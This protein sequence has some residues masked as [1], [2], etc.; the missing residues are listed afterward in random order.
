MALVLEIWFFSPRKITEHHTIFG[1]FGEVSKFGN[2]ICWEWCLF[3]R[4]LHRFETIFIH[5]G[6]FASS[7]SN[8]KFGDRNGE[9]PAPPGVFVGSII[10]NPWPQKNVFFSE[11]LS[12][13]AKTNP[14]NDQKLKA[15]EESSP[16][17]NMLNKWWIS[18]WF[19]A[20]YVG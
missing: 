17:S 11:D 9:F 5:A 12:V 14:N 8:Q 4:T 19:Q 3:Y 1:A 20:T 18:S 10:L 7:R 15:E 16:F 2:R 6:C 13:K